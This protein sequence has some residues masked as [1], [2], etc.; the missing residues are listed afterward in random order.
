MTPN[1]P[2]FYFICVVLIT[3][4]FFQ[5]RDD[6]ITLKHAIS[7]IIIE[8]LALFVLAWNYWLVV[9][10]GA[11]IILNVSSYITEN[12][13]K[14]LKLIRLIFL[15]LYLIIFAFLISPSTIIHFNPILLDS[16]LN[17]QPIFI[18]LAF[19]STVDWNYFLL[20]LSGLLLVLN[21]ANIF[22]RYLMETLYLVPHHKSRKS[23]KIDT[24]EYNRGRVIGI[25][26]R[27]LIYYFVLNNHLSAVGFILAAKGIT[28]FKELEDRQFAEYF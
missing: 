23:E 21:E 6:P 9:T 24:Q 1:P 28:R 17:L 20:V 8:S 18:L 2:Y 27:V 10:F 25:L 7:K 5:F 16:L 14:R 19:L 3:R 26:E 13:F 11:V 4:L 15:L 22:I 12:R